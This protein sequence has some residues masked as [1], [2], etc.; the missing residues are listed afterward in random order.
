LATTSTDTNIQDFSKA[1][2]FYYD[3]LNQTW[4]AANLKI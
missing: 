3:K 1:I 4:L 2:L